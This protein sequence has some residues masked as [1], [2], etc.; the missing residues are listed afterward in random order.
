MRLTHKK[1]LLFPQNVNTGKLGE[2]SA[3][4]AMCSCLQMFYKR[5]V[6]KFFKKFQ[7]KHTLSGIP[8]WPVFQ[9]I[10]GQKQFICVRV[11]IGKLRKIFLCVKTTQKWSFLLEISLLNVTKSAENCGFRH[12][13]WRN[14]YWKTSFFVQCKTF[15]ANAFI[16]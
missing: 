12:I 9:N 15:K 4:C 16:K 7:W 10:A 3:F 13:Y 6:P 2:I 8:C 14:L 5:V 11:L 1:T